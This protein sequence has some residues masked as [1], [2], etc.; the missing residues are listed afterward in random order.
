MSDFSFFRLVSL[1]S[2]S[3]IVFF[4]GQNGTKQTGAAHTRSVATTTSSPAD[5]KARD[6][7]RTKMFFAAGA[8]D[9]AEV[10]R[11]LQLKAD[12]ELPTATDP[13]KYLSPFKR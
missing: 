4:S 8:G 13:Y 7:V 12:I 10:A 9:A 1:V 5:I 2:F 3:L 6:L 11:L